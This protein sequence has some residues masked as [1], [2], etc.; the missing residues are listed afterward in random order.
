MH[1]EETISFPF[2]GEQ[3]T[4]TYTEI[5]TSAFAREFRDLH[6]M[7][8]CNHPIFI[9]LAHGSRLLISS[10]PSVLDKGRTIN[11]E[12]FDAMA[13]SCTDRPFAVS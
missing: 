1:R 11:R 8:K 13:N 3:V 2:H 7:V 4:W 10:L 6:A 9:R 5:D 12:F